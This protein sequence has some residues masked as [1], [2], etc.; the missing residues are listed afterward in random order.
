MRPFYEYDEPA[1]DDAFLGLAGASPEEAFLGLVK[2]IP[3]DGTVRLR[4]GEQ[5]ELGLVLRTYS[6]MKLLNWKAR[7]ELLYLACSTTP[8]G[9]PA[10]HEGAGAARELPGGRGDLRVVKGGGGGAAQP[11][12]PTRT[13]LGALCLFRGFGW[14]DREDF[15]LP[16][17]KAI[18]LSSAAVFEGWLV[19]L[20]PVAGWV[21]E[22]APDWQVLLP[23]IP[24]VS[25]GFPLGDGA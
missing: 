11:S 17:V 21:M 14:L 4:T 22:S 9:A 12:I 18:V 24:L 15:L 5:A 1:P 25:L 19:W 16:E 3:V 6:S 8:V 7:E 13:S 23:P 20:P 10:A 2:A